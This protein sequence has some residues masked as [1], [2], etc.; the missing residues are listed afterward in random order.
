MFATPAV[1]PA[2][3]VLACL[4]LGQETSQATGPATGSETTSTALS[5]EAIVG[6]VERLLWRDDVVDAN[7][8]DVRAASKVVTLEGT[9]ATLLQ[10][11]RAAALVASVRGVRGLVNLLEVESEQTADGALAKSVEDALLA[12]PATDSY[13]VDTTAEE[14]RITL[15]GTVDSWQERSLCELVA[16]SVRGVRSVDN[17]LRIDV[18]GTRSDAEMQAEIAARLQNDVMVDDHLIRVEVLDGRVELRGTVGSL[19]EKWRA[20]NDAYVRGVRSVEAEALDVESWARNRFRRSTIHASRSDDELEK[21]I[22][23]AFYYDP[24]VVSTRPSVTVEDGLATLR[25]SV[26]DL[27]AKRA[28]EATAR[29]V[30]GIWG[31]RNYLKVRPDEKQAAADVVSQARRALEAE[32]VVNAGAV[33]LRLLGGTLYLYGNVGSAVAKTRATRAVEGVDGVTKVRNL[34]SHARDW[35]FQPDERIED[36]VSSQL[37]WSA[38]VDDDKVHVTS[39]RGVVTLSG[40]VGTWSERMAAEACAWAGGAKDVE[41]RLRIE[42]RCY[43]PYDPSLEWTRAPS[44]RLQ[45]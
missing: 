39:E 32:P 11:D 43:G 29:H 17:Q 34:L 6:A 28:A 35:A 26:R 38:F 2:V 16:R 27:R 41:N 23:V 15:R 31:V 22:D 1:I 30:V 21:A 5:D 19:A 8:I 3:C 12:D 7:S 36:E 24:R 42:H 9:T 20:I 25:G 40:K 10:K 44:S 13:E 18:R 37:F 33:Q 14:G 4:A 45:R